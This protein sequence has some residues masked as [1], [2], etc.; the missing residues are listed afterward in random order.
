MP[1]NLARDFEDHSQL[2]GMYLTPNEAR[3]AYFNLL[4]PGIL[5]EPP[6]YSTTFEYSL[7]QVFYQFR[8]NIFNGPTPYWSSESASGFNERWLRFKQDV[9]GEDVKSDKLNKQTTGVGDNGLEIMQI[10]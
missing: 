8:V 2:L 7:S 10:Q 9:L 1:L 4:T 5:R 3:P 6:G